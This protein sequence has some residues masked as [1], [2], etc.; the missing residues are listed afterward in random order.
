MVLDP[1][2]PRGT[3]VGFGVPI[4]TTK[5]LNITFVEGRLHTGAI[6]YAAVK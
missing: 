3:I 1:M 5:S 6:P 4:D 2:P